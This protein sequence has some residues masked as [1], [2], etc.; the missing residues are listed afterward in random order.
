MQNEYGVAGYSA[1]W[2]TFIVAACWMP[3]TLI[4][5]TMAR[6]EYKRIHSADQAE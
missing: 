3:L 2:V 5:I 1:N 4:P 6:N